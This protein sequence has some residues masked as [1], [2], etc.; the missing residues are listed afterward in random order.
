MKIEIT[1][2]TTTNAKFDAMLNACKQAQETANAIKA[3]VNPIIEAV[4]TAKWQVIL[5][6]LDKFAYRYNRFMKL[7]NGDKRFRI[8]DSCISSLAGIQFIN[9]ESVWEN[10]CCAKFLYKKKDI[11]EVEIPDSNLIGCF[12]QYWN[13]NKIIEKLDKRLEDQMNAYI[14]DQA[15]QA[16]RRVETMNKL[17]G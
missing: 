5:E 10:Y 13:E 3:E 6:E 16:K 14:E 7:C 15:N 11:H 8:A 2:N 4:G 17:I 1:I 9:Y 12:I